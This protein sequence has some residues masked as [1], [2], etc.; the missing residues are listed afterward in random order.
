MVAPKGTVEPIIVALGALDPAR[1]GLPRCLL[2]LVPG[3]SLPGQLRNGLA[4]LGSRALRRVWPGAY[5]SPRADVERVAAHAQ[6]VAPA[7]SSLP[8]GSG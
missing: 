4:E 5:P 6:R 2:A 3:A 1:R 7:V 8:G